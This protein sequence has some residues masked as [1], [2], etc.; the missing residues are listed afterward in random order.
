M[1][2]R[3]RPQESKDLMTLAQQDV[4][5]R[6][7]LYEQ[8]AKLHYESNGEAEVEEDAGATTTAD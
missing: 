6:W 2:A 5:K 1:L 4:A 7:H 3:S 8:L